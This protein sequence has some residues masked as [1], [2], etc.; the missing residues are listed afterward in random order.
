MRPRRLRT[1]V[2]DFISSFPSCSFPSLLQLT[3]VIDVVLH[4]NRFNNGSLL[5]P[6]ICA[7]RQLS[8]FGELDICRMNLNGSEYLC[9]L[10]NILLDRLLCFVAGKIE[11]F[12]VREWKSI[13]C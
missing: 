5:F 1:A 8:V 2:V 9:F 12:K 6:T 13:S 4:A 7:S 10:L 3:S 11:E